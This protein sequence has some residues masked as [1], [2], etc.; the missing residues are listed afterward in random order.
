MKEYN[1]C[2]IYVHNLNSNTES[3]NIKNEKQKTMYVTQEKEIIG[4]KYEVQKWT[5]FVNLN[6]ELTYWINSLI[7]K[8]K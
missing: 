1:K 7:P 6:S 3:L 8:K 5:K 4:K 2:V